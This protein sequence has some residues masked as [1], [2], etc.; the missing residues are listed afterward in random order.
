MTEGRLYHVIA[1]GPDFI[2][3]GETAYFLFYHYA[4]GALADAVTSA[5]I[6]IK[7]DED[8]QTVLASTTAMTKS[9]TGTYPYSYAS[10]ATASVGWYTA[11][12]IFTNT[13]DVNKEGTIHF[14][15]LESI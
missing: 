10:A 8:G 12:A 2:Y 3:Q 7:C 15:V 13:A 6:G 11:Q 1:T 14:R 9:A 4:A 5:K